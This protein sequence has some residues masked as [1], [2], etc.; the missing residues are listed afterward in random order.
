MEGKYFCYRTNESLKIE[1][2]THD[3]NLGVKQ[4]FFFITIISELYFCSGHYLTVQHRPYIAQRIDMYD[5]FVYQEDDMI[6]TPSH[7]AAYVDESHFLH[8]ISV[9][10]NLPVDST[11]MVGFI[12][13]RKMDIDAHSS[14]SDSLVRIIE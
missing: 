2:S 13:Y 6:I 4:L 11:K 14:R 12:R 8:E 5:V 9:K 10:S 7:I 1:Y 3:T